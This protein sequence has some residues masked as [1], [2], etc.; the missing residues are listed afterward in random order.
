MTILSG[1][2]GTRVQNRL[3]AGREVLVARGCLCLVVAAVFSG[4]LLAPMFSIVS[5]SYAS[6][7]AS[8]GSGSVTVRVSGLPKG[9]RPAAVLRGPHGLRRSVPARGLSITR[10][11]AGSYRLVLRSVKITRASG[12]IERGAIATALKRKVGVHLGAGRHAVLRGSYTSIINPGLTTFNG[13]VVSVIGAAKDPSRV[14]LQGHVSL[15]RHAVLSLPPSSMLPRGLL[16][17]VVNVVYAR[18]K[19]TASLRTAS[20][21]EVAPNFQFDVPLRTSRQ[22]SASDVTASCGPASGLSP[23]RHIK[24]VSF[25]GG[26]DTV[27]VLGAHITDGVKAAVHFTAEAGLNVT[28][29]AGLACS[30]SASFYASGMAGPIPVTAGIEGDLGGSAA[31]GGILNTGGSVRVKAGAHTIGVPPALVWLPDVS[32]GHPQFTFNAKSFAQA[33]AGIGLTVKAGIGNGNLASVTLNIGT[34]LN[35]SAQPGACEW[36]AKFGQFSAE[37][38]LLKWHISTPK[39]PALFTHQLWNSSCGGGQNGGGMSVGGGPSGGSGGG[40]GG[41]DGGGGSSG[42]GEEESG[43]GGPGEEMSWT[44][45]EAPL[46]P[47]AALNQE[48]GF[49]AVACMDTATCVAIGSYKGS[50]G[51]EHGLIETLRDGS[52]TPTEAPLPAN[53]APGQEAKLEGVACAAAMTCVATGWYQ[54]TEEHNGQAVIETLQDGTWSPIEAPVPANAITG[55]PWGVGLPAC[56]EGGNCIAGGT[57]NTDGESPG[58]IEMLSGGTW[59]PLEAPLPPDATSQQEIYIGST[60]C[61]AVSTCIA[62]SLDGYEDTSGA[63]SAFIETLQNGAWTSIRAP[64]PA[65]A[66]TGGQPYVFNSNSAA[67]QSNESCIAVGAYYTEDSEQGLIETLSKGNWTARRA[68][69]PVNAAPG[70]SAALSSSACSTENNCIA[71]GAYTSTEAATDGLT[72]DGRV[73]ES[74]S[75]GSWVPIKAPL[76]PDGWSIGNVYS[77]TCLR[78]GACIAVG[79]YIDKGGNYQGLIEE[80]VR[81]SWTPTKAPLPPNA[82]PYQPYEFLDSAG[83]SAVAGSTCVVVGGYQDNEGYTHGLLETGEI[84]R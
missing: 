30:L 32:F 38:Q 64:L 71:M 59:T 72:W 8:K 60:A 36:N 53:A 1:L 3:G 49:R 7:F 75:D 17:N 27:N 31:V 40:E 43:G 80:P 51:R 68:P 9:Q 66:A 47:N 22:A 67:C 84:S 54:D 11:K 52:W 56:T 70:G 76:P 83:C 19:T 35:F 24:N 4:L 20:V 46:P 37:G 73:L 44:P 78:D 2:V 15:A 57:Y 45:I 55:G 50:D 14:V 48:G 74:L 58:L 23:Y 61:S 21:Y 10:A 25:S 41:S 6:A 28:A 34:S 81:G 65:D 42:G 39:T 82:T 13:K 79:N 77:T 12:S 5:V 16:S 62:L 69:Q 33:M 18:G 29:G 26:W 63:L